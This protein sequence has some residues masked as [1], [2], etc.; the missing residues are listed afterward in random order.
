MLHSNIRCVLDYA[1]DNDIP[2]IEVQTETEVDNYGETIGP[3]RRKILEAPRHFLFTKSKDDALSNP[4]VLRQVSKLNL[5]RIFLMGIYAKF[6]VYA[7]A[8]SLF[9]NGYKVFTS[10]QVLGECKWGYLNLESK[11]RRERQRWYRKN[12]DFI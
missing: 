1:I 7:T 6:C 2:L 11:E 5:S 3:V 8:R 12:V 10:N 9:Y 4:D